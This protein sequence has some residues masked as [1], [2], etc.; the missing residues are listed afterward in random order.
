MVHIAGTLPKGEANGLEA[1]SLRLAQELTTQK[2]FFVIGVVQTD[3]VKTKAKDLFPEPTIAFVRAELIPLDETD[4]ETMA[5]DLLQ[6]A[7]ELRRGGEGQQTF[8]LKD[9]EPKESETLELE[10]G[11]GYWF[12]VRDLPAG[13]FGLY[14]HTQYIETGKLRGNLLRSKH[15]EVAPG[16]Y[17]LHELPPSLRSIGELLIE[18]WDTNTGTSV[19]DDVVDAEVVDEDEEE[20][21][22]A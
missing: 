5:A 16:E 9:D 13:R 1:H 14:L 17:Q 2:R 11:P 3:S 6:A 18:E 10:N 8:N 15:G 20:E 4:L 21:Q 12:E 7:S 22:E 19:V